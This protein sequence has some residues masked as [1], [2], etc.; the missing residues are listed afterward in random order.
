MRDDMLE[1]EIRTMKLEK[2]LRLLK[3]EVKTA[4]RNS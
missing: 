1:V 4:S 3:E 2:E